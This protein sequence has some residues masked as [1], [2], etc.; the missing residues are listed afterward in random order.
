MEIGMAG[1]STAIGSAIAI[2]GKRLKELKAKSR[3]LILL[4]DGR[5]NAGDITPED[6]AKAV[7]TLGMKIYTIGVGGT[8]P[9]PFR[10]DTLFGTRIIHRRVDLDEVTLK[11][12]SEIGNGRYFRAADSRR[13]SDIYNIIDKEEKTEVK[14]KEFFHFRELYPFFLI[15]ALVFLAL[16]IFFRT[17]LLRVIP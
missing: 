17:T 8:G 9:A 12:I 5:N 11:K 2:S 15:P 3:I 16:E 6:A 13:L 1:D 14:V 7:R 4:T 10:V